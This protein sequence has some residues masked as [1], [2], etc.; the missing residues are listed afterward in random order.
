MHINWHSIFH[1]N[2]AI[3][4]IYSYLYNWNSKNVPLDLITKHQS[5]NHN[6]GTRHVKAAFFQKSNILCL[7]KNCRLN[8][9][10]WNVY[11]MFWVGVLTFKIIKDLCCFFLNCFKKSNEFACIPT[12]LIKWAD[13]VVAKFSKQRIVYKRTEGG[14]FH[15]V[16]S[17]LLSRLFS[18]MVPPMFTA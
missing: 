1:R 14:H 16:F 6:F 2:Q 3:M 8:C 18:R 11:H 15:D 13:W 12:I 4:G 10:N 17:G 5:N 7:N 9:L